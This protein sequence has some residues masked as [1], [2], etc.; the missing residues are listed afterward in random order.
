MN[1]KNSSRSST[2]FLVDSILSLSSKSFTPSISSS[3]PFHH[4]SPV[5]SS[6]AGGIPVATSSTGLY[7]LPSNYSPFSSGHYP[8]V[9]VTTPLERNSSRQSHQKLD[10]KVSPL[11]QDDRNR[12]GNRLRTAFT[13]TQ[14]VHLEREF[15]RNM[16]LSRLRRIEIAHTLNLSEKQVKIW[17]QNRRVKYKKEFGGGLT[18]SSPLPMTSSM[19]EPSS[20]K[21]GKMCACG[22]DCHSSN[23]GSSKTSNTPCSRDQEANRIDEMEYGIISSTGTQKEEEE[24]VDGDDE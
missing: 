7:N 4:E 9:V 17:F 18:P 23:L 20:K 10:S 21:E 15:A 6:N 2:S 3:F 16:Y 8:H 11:N 5:A 14:I 12:G 19:K 22:C 24:D 1:S 13:S